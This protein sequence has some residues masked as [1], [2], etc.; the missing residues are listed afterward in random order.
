VE[1]D[2]P[3]L[4]IGRQCQ[5]LG[6]SRSGFYYQPRGENELNLFLMRWIDLEYTAHPFFGYRKMD[7]RVAYE[8]DDS[9]LPVFY[10]DNPAHT[11]QYT[12][13]VQLLGKAFDNKM[14][15]IAGFYYFKQKGTDISLSNSFFGLNPNAPGYTGPVVDNTSF[16]GY[17]QQTTEILPKLSFTTGARFTVDRRKTKVVQYTAPIAPNANACQIRDDNGVILPF[18]AALPY[19]GCTFDVSKTFSKPT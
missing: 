19:N 11:K 5:L 2:H 10:V 3:S 18:N 12:D 7:Y 4:S 9:P 1:R 14:N 17:A 15:W 13:E 16:S 6:L 8:G